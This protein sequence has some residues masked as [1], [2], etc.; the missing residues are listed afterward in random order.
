[1]AEKKKWSAG[2]TK[3]EGKLHEAL[4]VPKDEKIPAAKLHAAGKKGGK[5]GKEARL[6]ETLK[7]LNPKHASLRASRRPPRSKL[8]PDLMRDG[9]RTSPA[10][11]S[12][13]S[14][15]RAGEYMGPMTQ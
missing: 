9:G 4:H 3:H 10:D 14:P 1:M 12:R 5:V 11:G 13:L 2:A 15:G 7:G 8:S 6:A